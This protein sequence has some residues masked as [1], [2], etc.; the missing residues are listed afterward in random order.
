[1][2]FYLPLPHLPDTTLP[3]PASPPPKEWFFHKPGSDAAHPENIHINK[4]KIN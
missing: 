4:K 1:M 2:A 3:L